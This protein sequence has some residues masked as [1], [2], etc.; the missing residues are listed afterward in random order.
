V[1]ATSAG[2]GGFLQRHSLDRAT[3]LTITTGAGTH[4]APLAEFAVAGALHFVK[5]VPGL[6]R[7]QR[8]HEWTRQVTGQL[9]GRRVTVVGLGSIGRAAAT[10]FANLGARVTGL[11]R[12]GGTYDL[13]PGVR[14]ATVDDLDR[15]LPDTDVLVLACPLTPQTTNLIDA[16]RVGSLPPGAIVVNVARG[17]VIDES[18]MTK[19]LASGALAGAALDVFA[20][21][22]LPRSSPLW[23][24][25]NVLI[26]SHSAATAANENAMLTDLFLDNLRRYL[27]GR[28]LRNLY[29]PERGY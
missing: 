11:G 24:L 7:R 23:D 1:Q 10:A 21:E 9:G 18:A 5:D 22:P 16:G 2:V 28:P 27:D 19:A 20:T 6:Q 4:A 3:G 26:C 13:P 25:P 12:P 8:A 17:P 15:V 29:R 14:G